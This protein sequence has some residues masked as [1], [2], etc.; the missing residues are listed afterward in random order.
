[1][2]Y[3]A[4]R[5]CVAYPAESGC[6]LQKNENKMIPLAGIAVG[7]GWVDPVNMIPAYPDMVFNMG[8]CDA[9]EKGAAHARSHPE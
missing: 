4:E 8:M 7:D 2:A 1:M 5:G 9:S 6:V 3:R